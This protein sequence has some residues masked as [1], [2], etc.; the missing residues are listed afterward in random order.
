[1][2]RLRIYEY[3]GLYKQLGI[4]VTERIDREPLWED[5]KKVKVHPKFRSHSDQENAVSHSALVSVM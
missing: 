1:M 5:Y 3:E 2:N 4:P